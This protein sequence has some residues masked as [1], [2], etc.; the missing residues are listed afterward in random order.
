MKSVARM[1]RQAPVAQNTGIALSYCSSSF[2]IVSKI[3][4]LQKGYPNKSINPPQAPAYS[5]F[6]FDGSF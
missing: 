1:K 5:N 2:S 4:P 6:S 3:R